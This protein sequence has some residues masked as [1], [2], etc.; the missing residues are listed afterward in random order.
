[1]DI[2]DQSASGF[3]RREIVNAAGAAVLAGA[4]ASQSHGQSKDGSMPF[5]DQAFRIAGS[6]EPLTEIEVS[7]ILA[8]TASVAERRIRT[9]QNF[10]VF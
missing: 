8:K 1:M 2:K 7:S 3:R 10:V 4:V 5:L 9:I 6:F